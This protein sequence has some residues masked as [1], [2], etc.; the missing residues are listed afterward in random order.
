MNKA[1]YLGTLITSDGRVSC[2]IKSR[3]AQAKSAF[4]KMRSILSNRSLSMDIRIR[5]LQC[6]I[7][8]ILFYGCEAW[9][10][11]KKVQRELEAAEMWFI[12]RMLRISWTARKTNEEVLREAEVKRQIYQKLEAGSQDS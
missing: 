12:R 10:I 9:N 5:V 2:E 1:R 4:H 11:N 7:E 6:Y 3:I 8:P